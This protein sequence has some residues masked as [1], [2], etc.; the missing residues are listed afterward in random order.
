M[1]LLSCS[2][3]FCTLFFMAFFLATGNVNTTV[4]PSRVGRSEGVLLLAKQCSLFNLC[5]LV[6]AKGKDTVP[7]TVHH[8]VIRVDAR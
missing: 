3:E 5:S 1:T 8:A 2:L 6:V 7:D 4:S